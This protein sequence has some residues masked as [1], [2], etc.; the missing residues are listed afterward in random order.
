[1]LGFQ[2]SRCSDVFKL[3]GGELHSVEMLGLFEVE[4]L[5]P[6]GRLPKLIGK[7]WRGG[8]K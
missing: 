4:A 5:N 1:M 7:Y 8:E 3:S 6:R 2:K